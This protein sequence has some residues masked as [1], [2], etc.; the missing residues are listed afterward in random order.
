VSSPVEVD[1]KDLVRY[2]FE[3]KPTDRRAKERAEK[4]V[5][6]KRV[7]QYMSEKAK[8]K[9]EEELKEAEWI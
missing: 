6:V 5:R 4:S 3:S 7:N 8:K 1:M 9:I 2:Y